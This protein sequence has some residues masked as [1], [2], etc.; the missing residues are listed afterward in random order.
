MVLLPWSLAMI[1]TRS[2]CQTP[3]QLCVD[4]NEHVGVREIGGNDLR[5]GGA[6]IDTDGF[7]GHSLRVGF[8]GWRGEV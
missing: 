8:G 7:T 6:Q 1:S 5:V 2:F 4:E 3:T